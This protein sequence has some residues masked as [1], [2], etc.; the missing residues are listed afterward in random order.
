MAR[1]YETGL[2]SYVNTKFDNLEFIIVNVCKLYE[3][4]YLISKLN[5]IKKDK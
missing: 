2:N 1:R 5:M 3:N 4:N